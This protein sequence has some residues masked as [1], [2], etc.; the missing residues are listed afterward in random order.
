MTVKI[1]TNKQKYI[2]YIILCISIGI[3]FF[4]TD[5]CKKNHSKY[6]TRLMKIGV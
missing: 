3:E 6:Y 4:L 1:K 5:L 2:I